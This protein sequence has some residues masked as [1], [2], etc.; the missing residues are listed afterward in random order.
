L[1][2]LQSDRS[3]RT[4]QRVE[5]LQ[6]KLAQDL[7]ARGLIVIIEWGTWARTE[8][9]TLRTGARALG[10]AVEL[11]FL[12]APIEVL[13]ERLHGRNRESPPI[14]RDE[15]LRWAQLFEV[16]TPEEIAMFDSPCVEGPQV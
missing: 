5:A 1:D 9:D 10:A 3:E 8:R 13:L 16:P 15:L 7:L 6:W 2:F 4:R 11:H 14:T 12:D